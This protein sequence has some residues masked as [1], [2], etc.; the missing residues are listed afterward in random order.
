M[1][2]EQANNVPAVKQTTAVKVSDS[3]KMLADWGA[4]ALTARDFTIPRILLI[5][6]LSPQVKESKGKIKEGDLLDSLSG[7]VVGGLDKPLEIIPF[8]MERVYYVKSKPNPQA[9]RFEFDR[10]VPITAQNEEEEFE[11]VGE[12][13]QPEQWYRMQNFYVL[14]PKE[15]EA[16]TS[17]PYVIGFRS[18]AGGKAGRALTTTMFMKNA[19]AGKTPAHMTMELSV[20]AVTNADGS[21]ASMDVKELR[22]SKDFE[23]GEAFDWVTKIKK[24]AVKVDQK[25]AFAEDPFEQ[26]TAAS[27]AP[28]A[29]APGAPEG[30]DY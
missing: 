14:L 6:A 20:K 22:E 17:L 24:G 9:K 23:I 1:N 8:Y 11:Q 27:A 18:S 5:Q 3:E 2:M 7:E 25:S 21:F 16:G 15:V 13:N 10:I 26:K 19:K 30:D 4:P 29:P 28:S 12:N